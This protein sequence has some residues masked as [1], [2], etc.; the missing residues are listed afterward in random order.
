[1]NK[2]RRSGSEQSGLACAVLTGWFHYIALGSILQVNGSIAFPSV[3][4]LPAVKVRRGTES[5]SGPSWML[6]M[7]RLR[8]GALGL[9]L[10][11]RLPQNG[12]A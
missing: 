9:N 1:M 2:S 11:C 7:R 3:E 8:M 6:Y 5:L 4:P 12:V 10:K